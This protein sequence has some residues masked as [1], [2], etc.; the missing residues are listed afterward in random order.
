MT[1]RLAASLRLHRLL[2]L[3]LLAV[4]LAQ[5]LGAMHRIVHLPH[6]A[7][8]DGQK[9]TPTPHRFAALFAGHASE[10]G[11]ELYDQ[12]SHADLVPGAIASLTAVPPAMPDEP[13][14]GARHL[15]AP[16]TGFLA[17]GPPR[18]A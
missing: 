2:P 3:L 9:A 11:C 17:R 14:Y 1:P 7:R 5:T 10:Q 6:A 15:A 16:A 13:R 4:A 18:T 8:G 12:L